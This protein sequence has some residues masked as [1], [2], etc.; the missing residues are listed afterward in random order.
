MLSIHKNFVTNWPE[1]HKKENRGLAFDIIYS[2]AINLKLSFIPTSFYF[3]SSVRIL[4]R[5]IVFSYQPTNVYLSVPDCTS[6][7]KT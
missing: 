5:L 6:V 4:I 1:L 7:S 3:I 2:T